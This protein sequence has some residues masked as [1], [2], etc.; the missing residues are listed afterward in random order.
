MMGGVGVCPEFRY[1]LFAG[2][3]ASREGLA[4]DGTTKWINR[5]IYK[6]FR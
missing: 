6:F 5:N 4:M 3:A 2:K 1:E